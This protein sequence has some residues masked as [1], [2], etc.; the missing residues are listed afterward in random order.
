MKDELATIF[1]SVIALGAVMAYA[2]FN[3]GWLS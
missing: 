2:A 3:A 1:L